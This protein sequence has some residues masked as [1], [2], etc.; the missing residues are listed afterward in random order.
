MSVWPN[1]EP[2]VPLLLTS[3]ALKRDDL[4]FFWKVFDRIALRNDLIAYEVEKTKCS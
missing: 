3:R 2:G 4:S 1:M